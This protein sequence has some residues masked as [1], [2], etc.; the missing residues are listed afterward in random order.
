MHAFFPDNR[1]QSNPNSFLS[2][3]VIIGLLHLRLFLRLLPH[4][5]MAPSSRPARHTDIIYQCRVA[6]KSSME[7]S[8]RAK[9]LSSPS[10]DSVAK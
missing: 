9:G 8:R 6:D 1:M 10:F 4:T 5:C 7:G 3:L 2:C